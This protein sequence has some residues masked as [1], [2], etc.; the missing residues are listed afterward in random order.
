[1]IPVLAIIMLVLLMILG[2][3][4]M[5]LNR[6]TTVLEKIAMGMIPI[7]LIWIDRPLWLADMIAQVPLYKLLRW[8]FREITLLTFFAHL[9]LLGSWARVSP[10][11]RRISIFVGFILMAFLLVNQRAPSFNL[12]A[13]DRELVLSGESLSWWNEIK[14]ESKQTDSWIVVMEKDVFDRVGYDLPFSLMGAYNYPS[15][16]QMP[17]LTGYIGNW[18]DFSAIWGEEKPYHWSG[19]FTPEAGR[20]LHQLYPDLC[21]V[22]VLMTESGGVRVTAHR[23]ATRQS[24]VKELEPRT[25]KGDQ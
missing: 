9:I 6:E 10:V 15:Y 12:M 23:P 2:G 25:V 16:L 7:L 22:E 5:I 24:W 19:V 8:P 1:M 13:T 3:V 17:S 21:Y 11:L 14:K 4:P 18:I 20:Q